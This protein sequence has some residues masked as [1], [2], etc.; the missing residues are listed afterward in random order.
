MLK[1]CSVSNQVMAENRQPSS[2]GVEGLSLLVLTG[3]WGEPAFPGVAG[4]SLLVLSVNRRVG[5]RMG[6]ALGWGITAV[7]ENRS[8]LIGMVFISIMCHQSINVIV[9]GRALL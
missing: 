6:F 4:L 7:A 1:M 5:V 9:S 3:G 8:V 2:P